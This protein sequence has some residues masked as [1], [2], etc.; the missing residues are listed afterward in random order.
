MAGGNGISGAKVPSRVERERGTC[1][2][3]PGWNAEGEV[4]FLSLTKV[5]RLSLGRNFRWVENTLVYYFFYFLFKLFT[6]CIMTFDVSDT[7]K[8]LLNL[9]GN[10]AMTLTVT[11]VG[12]LVISR[13]TP[14]AMKRRR[15]NW[16]RHPCA[17]LIL[18]LV[19]K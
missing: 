9:R 8:N 3:N 13:E 17:L 5:G 10:W 4:D 12:L 15:G 18:F 1:G 11:W 2:L 6:N 19:T 14:V 7:S 16:S